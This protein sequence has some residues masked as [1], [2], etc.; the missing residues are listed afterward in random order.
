MP[1]TARQVVSWP[2]RGRTSC[3][4][5]GGRTA[6]DGPA[7]GGTDRVAPGVTH[8]HECHD[9]GPPK[10]IAAAQRCQTRLLTDPSIQRSLRVA[11]YYLL[12]DMKLFHTHIE[13][14]T[15]SNV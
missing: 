10:F 2:G 4:H 13:S 12:G 7:R 5:A 15:A 11:T 14:S 6:A 3:H 8:C 1:A 9:F